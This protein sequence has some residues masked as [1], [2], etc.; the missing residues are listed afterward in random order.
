MKACKD[1]FPSTWGGT[2]MLP[3]GKYNYTRD[4][5]H[6]IPAWV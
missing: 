2:E 1:D 5:V 4:P 3:I 6:E